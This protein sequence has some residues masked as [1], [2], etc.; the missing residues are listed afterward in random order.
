MKCDQCGKNQAYVRQSTD[1]PY[2]N[3][4][5]YCMACGYTKFLKHHFN[6]S[7]LK[8]PNKAQ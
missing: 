5:V 4:E 3:K 6:A 7:N 2:Y 1:S 8:V